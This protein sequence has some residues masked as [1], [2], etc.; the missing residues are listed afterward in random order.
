MA[1]N[2][3]KT[4]I[5][6]GIHN[7]KT[8]E[9][10]Y[11]NQKSYLDFILSQD[12]FK[13][14]NYYHIFKNYTPEPVHVK[15]CNDNGIKFCEY[16]CIKKKLRKCDLRDNFHYCGVC[17]NGERQ[18]ARRM[19]LEDTSEYGKKKKQEIKDKIDKKQLAEYKKY[20]K[21]LNK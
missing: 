11:A 1:I 20:L 7:G 16:C 12:F 15:Y 19:L 13:K 9:W 10:L 5:T 21:N 2:K 4:K 6:F 18:H 3:S 14:F 17:Y 8:I